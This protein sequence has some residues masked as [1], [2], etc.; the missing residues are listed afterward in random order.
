M[1]AAGRRCSLPTCKGCRFPMVSNLFGTI[2]R[3]RFLFRDTL[4]SVRQ[5]DRAE[6]RSGRSS[7]AVRCGTAS[8]PL[9]A[10]RMQ[11]QARV[12]AGRCSQ[13]ETTIGQLPQLSLLAGRRRA[14]SSRCR[15]STPRTPTSPGWRH[16]NLGMYRVQLSGNAVRA[17]PRG[18]PALP[19]P[20]RHRRASRGGDAARRAVAREHLRRRARRR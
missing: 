1:P 9:T 10:W 14:R 12:V 11:P 18:R 16:S 17:G 3:A 7:A 8:A 19:D 5:A 4:D 13:H 15:R 20:S 6:D 2:E